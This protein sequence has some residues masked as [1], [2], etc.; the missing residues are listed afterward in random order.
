MDS[1]DGKENIEFR[2]VQ[3]TGKSSYIVSLPKNWIKINNIKRGD[4]IAITQEEEGQLRINK[5]L[6]TKKKEKPAPKI[7]LDSLS[8]SEL[9]TTILGNYVMGVDNLE[10]ISKK[11]DMD[12]SQKRAAVDSIRNLIGFEVISESANSIKV[13][14]LLEPSDFNLEEVVNRLALVAS[15]M[16]K[17]AIKGIVDTNLENMKEIEAQDDEVDRLYLLIQRL[18]TLGI[19]DKAIARKIGLDNGGAAMGWS[20]VVRSIERIADASMEISQQTES[21]K[22]IKIPSDIQKLYSKL[23]DEAITLIDEVLTAGTQKDPKAAHEII[24]KIDKIFKTRSEIRK[25]ESEK[26]IE[27]KILLNLEVINCALKQSLEYVRDYS[28]VIINSEYWEHIK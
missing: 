9:V 24:R 28:K 4:T 23:S 22:N 17:K 2:K 11:K 5:V 18:L 16:F 7:L 21:F 10:I 19:R 14:N 6:E 1:S 27:P 25:A 26:S 3:I 13:K 12:S 8:D 20:V 15:S